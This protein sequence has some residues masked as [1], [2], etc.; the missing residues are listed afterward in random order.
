M[1]WIL[2]SLVLLSVVGGYLAFG[3]LTAAGQRRRGGGLL[4]TCGAIPFF[5]VYWVGWYVRDTLVAP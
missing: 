1:S 2:V 5:P 3:A 4:L